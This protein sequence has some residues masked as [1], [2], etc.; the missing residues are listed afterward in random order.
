M[1]RPTVPDRL[2]A[3]HDVI[4]VV[5]EEP[6]QPPIVVGHRTSGRRSSP[7]TEYST[8]VGRCSTVRCFGVWSY[9]TSPRS[10]STSSSICDEWYAGTAGSATATSYAPVCAATNAAT[11]S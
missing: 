1:D 8:S 9:Q 2:L 10:I 4:A 7:S 11:A 5:Q 3:L 6:A